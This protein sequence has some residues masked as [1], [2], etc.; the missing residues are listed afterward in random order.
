MTKC[1]VMKVTSSH[2]RLGH[3]LETIQGN[4]DY[5]TKRLVMPKT[6]ADVHPWLIH[7]RNKACHMCVILE[8]F[9]S[10]LH[11]LNHLRSRLLSEHQHHSYFADGKSICQSY[12]L[13]VVSL[14]AEKKV[15][16]KLFNLLIFLSKAFQSLFLFLCRACWLLLT[17]SH[18]KRIWF[19]HDSSHNLI[20]CESDPL[21]PPADQ[22]LSSA[23]TDA[24]KQLHD[25]FSYHGSPSLSHGLFI[26]KR[27]LDLSD[28]GER[29]SQSG[30]KYMRW[31]SIWYLTSCWEW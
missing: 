4:D 5:T 18:Y 17:S 27:R 1:A 7:W 19:S 20:T 23:K 12:A 10:W 30:L 13:T 31:I 25:L 6:C 22:V 28:D 2:K 11:L 8:L 21:L 26:S 29:K 15:P 24:A 9:L 3:S 16:L 14:L